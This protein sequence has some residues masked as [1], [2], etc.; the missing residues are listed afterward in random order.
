MLFVLYL[1]CTSG[2]C[3]FFSLSS[4]DTPP[5]NLHFQARKLLRPRAPPVCHPL[6]HLEERRNHSPRIG[7][8]RVDHLATIPENEDRIGWG[9]ERPPRLRLAGWKGWL[10]LQLAW[11]MLYR[12]EKQLRTIR[13]YQYYISLAVRFSILILPIRLINI[14][15]N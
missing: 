8:G 2:L 3:V 12:Q 9:H 7:A 13:S 4:K 15:T 11:Y 10:R 6:T 14:I 1:W 5:P